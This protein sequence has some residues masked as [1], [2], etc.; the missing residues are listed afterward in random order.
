M[1]R[2][3]FLTDYP[4]DPSTNPGGLEAVSVILAERLSMHPDVE[5]SVLTCEPGLREERMIEKD[6]I[7]RLYIPSPQPKILTRVV[8]DTPRIARKIREIAPD[9]VH[10]HLSRYTYAAL[11]T[12]LPVIWTVHGITLN[13][14]ADWQ[15]ISGRIRGLIYD[16]VDRSCLK[17]IGHIIEIS[18]YV[19]EVFSSYTDARFYTIENPVDDRFFQIEDRQEEGRIL[20]VG[21]IEP[22]KG[23]LMLLETALLLRNRGV[24]FTLHIVGQSKDDVYFNKMEQYVKEN[25]LGKRVKFLGVRIGE[26][27]AEEYAEAA[28]CVLC[29]REETAPITILEAMAAGKAMVATSVGGN[30][31]LIKQGETGFLVE[32]PNSADMAQR[33]ETLLKEKALRVKIGRE[34]RKEAERRFHP[35]I[36]TK[37]TIQAYKKILQTS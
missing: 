7:K 23:T 18:P 36:I 10:S 6:G 4:E 19:H 35:E 37:K 30:P 14:K 15:G 34:A 5:I 9:I 12:D 2:I 27:L 24:D 28:L 16:T 32:Y 3:L 17:R 25:R 20:T 26:E 29:S 31:W 8:R 13:Q 21:S 33:M 22:R 1:M 11:R